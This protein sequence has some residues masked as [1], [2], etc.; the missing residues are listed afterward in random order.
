MWSSFRHG[1]S[2][3]TSVVSYA[4][5]KLICWGSAS[6]PANCCIFFP[7][8]LE[9]CLLLAKQRGS[10]R[11]MLGTHMFWHLSPPLSFGRWPQLMIKLL[12]LSLPSILMGGGG[13]ES[14][15]LWGVSAAIH[16]HTNSHG[17]HR[18][19]QSHTRCYF[20]LPGDEP[21]GSRT[22]GKNPALDTRQLNGLIL[23]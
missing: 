12:L 13:G 3:E 11:H 2:D 14:R 20:L 7:G 10:C 5:Q 15:K 19:S 22:D 17:I 4:S 8:F 6:R 21:P 1:L 23:A 9:R 18:R 16:S